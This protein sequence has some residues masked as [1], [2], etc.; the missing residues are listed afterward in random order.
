MSDRPQLAEVT[1]SRVKNGRVE[2]DVRFFVPGT[3]RS[4]LPLYQAFPGGVRLPE[5]GE[6]VIIERLADGSWVATQSLSGSPHVP[7]T[8]TEGDYHLQWADGTALKVHKSET[9]TDVQIETSGDITLT[10]AGNVFIN[11]VDF[12]NH[13]HDYSWSDAAGSG[14]TGGPQ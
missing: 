13:T 11:G 8:L 6:R 3:S 1:A 7:D 2:V 4:G 10:A 5:Q 12:D 9:A 14:T